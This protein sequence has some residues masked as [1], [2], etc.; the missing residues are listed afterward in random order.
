MGIESGTSHTQSANHT[1][2]PP[3]HSQSSLKSL[4]TTKIILSLPV[5]ILPGYVETKIHM[6][7]S[8]HTLPAWTELQLLVCDGTLVRAKSLIAPS[9]AGTNLNMV[10]QPRGGSGHILNARDV[11]VRTVQRHCHIGLDL[12]VVATAEIENSKIDPGC[13]YIRLGDA[14]CTAELQAVSYSVPLSRRI[15]YPLD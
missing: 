8:V 2:R 4:I 11:Q 13:N 15:G 12:E 5:M 1:P 7:I 9:E 6:R 10:G 14:T 3:N